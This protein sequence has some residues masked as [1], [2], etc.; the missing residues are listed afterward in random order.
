MLDAIMRLKV[1]AKKKRETK[2]ENLCEDSQRSIKRLQ[3][4]LVVRVMIC[5]EIR[6]AEDL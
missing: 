5:E 4:F 3:V 2:R 1:T 6:D